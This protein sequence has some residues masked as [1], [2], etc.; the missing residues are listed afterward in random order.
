MPR[1]SQDWNDGLAKDLHD[2]K[3][4][5][6]FIVAA[7]EDGM[8]LKDVLKKVILA[9]GL[10]EVGKKVGMKSPNLS[11]VLGLKGNPTQET[12]N[13]LLKPFGLKLSVAPLSKKKAA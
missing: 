9:I 12:F 10:K 13:R 6:E 3:F 2:P 7:L 8:D 4:A 5:K 11:R 1:R